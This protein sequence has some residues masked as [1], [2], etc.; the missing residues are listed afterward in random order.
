[1]LL[2]VSSNVVYNITTKETPENANP[3]LALLVT[4]LVGSLFSFIMY[5]ITSKNIN[6]SQNFREINW[7]SYLLGL[8]IV[9]LE[10]GY[11]YLYRAGWK[12]SLGSIV[13][14]ISLA[15]ILI[16]IGILLYKESIGIKQIFGIV[17]CI[18]GLI[19]INL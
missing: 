15:V 14:N 11:I 6:L 1:M 12:I 17:L 16:L 2:I 8:S 13:A 9:G 3:F 10:V 19:C 5:L 7:T 18:M 4:Y